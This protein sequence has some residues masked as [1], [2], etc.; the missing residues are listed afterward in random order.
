MP[1][2]G[3]RVRCRGDGNA[4]LCC[5]R[6]TDSLPILEAPQGGWPPK[7]KDP[8]EKEVAAISPRTHGQE[9]AEAAAVAVA[10]RAVKAEGTG[11]V[12]SEDDLRKEEDDQ[13]LRALVGEA[14]G[15]DRNA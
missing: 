1:V 11:R 15:E 7:S 6:N 4:A 3:Q 5:E 9:A 12:D 13:L 14:N 10:E 8:T 2:Q